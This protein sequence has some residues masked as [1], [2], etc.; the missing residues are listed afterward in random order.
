MSTK[1]SL[2]TAMPGHA[3]LGLALP[4]YAWICFR[5]PGYAYGS[6]PYA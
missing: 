3:F 4:L 6:P 2:C 5:I 1:A